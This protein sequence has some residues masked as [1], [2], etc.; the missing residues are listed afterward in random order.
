[1]AN[2]S[3]ENPQDGV[4]YYNRYNRHNEHNR[5]NIQNDFCKSVVDGVSDETPKSIVES[6][7]LCSSQEREAQPPHSV[8]IQAPTPSLLDQDQVRS[9]IIQLFDNGEDSSQR[10]KL[11]V[12]L[13]LVDN[14]NPEFIGSVTKDFRNF[15]KYIPQPYTE[16]I[17]DCARIYRKKIKDQFG[18]LP[19]LGK[20]HFNTRR[21]SHRQTIQIEP[22]TL[23]AVYW[24]K[25]EGGWS[26]MLQIQNFVIQFDLFN[27]NLT[28][29]QRKSG[30]KAQEIWRNAQMQ[31]GLRPK[32]WAEQRQ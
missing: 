12:R 4:H 31:Q 14:T 19:H 29:V 7:V 5:K 22:N 15:K 9:C 18:V 30:V 11:K 25:E 23:V 16:E 1:M 20:L 2:D 21:N 26:G 8:A 17:I 3:T 6:N 24:D 13:N 10:Y 28:E 27:T 32:T